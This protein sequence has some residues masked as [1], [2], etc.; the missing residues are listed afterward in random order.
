MIKN[1]K[2][3]YILFPLVI[4]VWGLVI[5]RVI[6]GQSGDRPIVQRV[7]TNT[8]SSDLRHEIKRDSIKIKKLTRDPFLGTSYQPAPKGKVKAVK[9]KVNWPSISIHGKVG[10]KTH[11]NQVY[12][13]AI[14]NQPYTIKKG[15]TIDGITLLQATDKGVILRYQ[16]EVKSLRYE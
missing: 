10:D 11:Q 3:L 4:G 7:T 8:K 6:E 1:K 15:E 13:I 2:S 5:Y 12:I 9:E 16:E 14:G